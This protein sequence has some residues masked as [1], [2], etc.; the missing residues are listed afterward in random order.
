[1]VHRRLLTGAALAGI[2]TVGACT[3]TDEGQPP[4]ASIAVT[5]AKAGAEA[6]EPIDFSYRFTRVAGAPALS[7]DLWVFVHV[8]DEAGMLLW[9]DDHRPPVP[10]STWTAEPVTYG[11]TM[12]V[13][14]LSYAGPVHVEAG[15]YAPG[16]G[17]RVPL[18]GEARGNRSY[19]VAS[20]TVL[21]ASKG[22]FVAYGDGWHGA[23]RAPQDPLREWRWSSGDARLSFR[24]PG[25]D[26]SLWLELDQPVT[27]V[28]T[29]RVEVREGPI[30]LATLA[31][32]PGTRHVE[33]GP[34]AARARFR[35][36]RR[37]RPARGADVRAGGRP[38]ARQPG[39]ARARDPRLQRLRRAQVGVATLPV[40]VVL[41]N[42]RSLYNTGAFFRTAD[43]C[44]VEKLVLCGI[45]P[46]PNQGRRQQH[47]IAKTA[48][49]A[50]SRGAVGVRGGYGDGR[51]QGVSGGLS[52]GGG[53]ELRRVRS[54]STSG[55]RRGRCAWCS[56]TRRP[57][58]R[59][60]SRA[61][62]TPTSGFRCWARSAR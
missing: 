19:P 32:E 24:H 20:F 26:A 21:P 52:R 45:T 54:T 3:K 39:Q 7:D 2:F 31:I 50:E 43:G 56:A 28:G 23:E 13:P 42:V 9:T 38:V 5:L 35:I 29:Q 11:R 57:A 48:L 40:I 44:A 60:T 25:G 62:S 16:D 10:P 59:P 4:V 46:R 47:A 22:V 51:G 14:R 17:A 34:G 36:G 18:T 41:D 49:G 33:P 55:R 30:L 58:S 12:F 61:A 53:G 37:A 15:L 6:G 27:A 8:V 1:M